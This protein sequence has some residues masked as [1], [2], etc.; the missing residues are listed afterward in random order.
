M[1][2]DPTEAR[3]ETRFSRADAPTSAIGALPIN[4]ELIIYLLA[5]AV[6]AIIWLASDEV[7]AGA[8]TT[9]MVALTIAYLVSRGIAKASRVYER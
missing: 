6:V 1:S 7:G 3:S 9:L 5:V 4:P 2:T 8:F